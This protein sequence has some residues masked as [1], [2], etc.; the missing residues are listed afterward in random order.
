MNGSPVGDDFAADAFPLFETVVLLHESSRRCPRLRQLIH[1]R[2]ST[3]PTTT[4]S[5][6][7][8]IA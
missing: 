7:K 5:G 1:R 4:G 8:A 6:S 3:S 2:A